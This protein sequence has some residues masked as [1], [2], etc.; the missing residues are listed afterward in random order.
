MGGSEE[1]APGFQLKVR[2]RQTLDAHLT[3]S[4]RIPAE[5]IVSDGEHEDRFNRQY[6]HLILEITQAYLPFTMAVV[7]RSRLISTEYA[8][9]N[10][11]PDRSR[12]PLPAEC[13]LKLYDRRHVDNIRDDFDAGQRYNEEKESAYQRYLLDPNKRSHDFVADLFASDS[14]SDDDLEDGGAFEDYLAHR[15]ESMWEKEVQAYERM[16]DLQGEMIPRLLGLVNYDPP[17]AVIRDGVPQD[18]LVVKGVLLEYIPA[19]TLTQYITCQLQDGSPIDHDAIAHVSQ[20]AVALVNTIGENGVLNEDVRLDNILVRR[21][22]EVPH[23]QQLNVRSCSALLILVSRKRL[24]LS[25][26][27][28][29]L[30]TRPTAPSW[31]FNDGRYT[32]R[33]LAV[34]SSFAT[35]STADSLR[36]RRLC[37]LP[38]PIRGRNG[39]GVEEGQA[40]AG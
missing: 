1:Y 8:D 33:M 13:I 23:L 3:L 37:L 17:L 18:C 19:I 20:Q 10:N 35:S 34:S 28:Y 26:V 38:S 39:G 31:P 22:G 29:T 16:R 25:F 12:S 27:D 5:T 14:G 4:G 9:R 6:D 2:F 40:N 30:H 11:T 24:S 21:Q 7:C 36:R 15:C 32:A